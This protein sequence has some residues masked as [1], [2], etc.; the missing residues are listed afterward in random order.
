MMKKVF[1]NL[2]AALIIMV[3]LILLALPESFQPSDIALLLA[4]CAIYA[5]VALPKE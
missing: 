3:A 2:P 5:T 4:T 1:E